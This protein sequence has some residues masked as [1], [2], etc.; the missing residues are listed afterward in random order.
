ML[1]ITIK[2]NQLSRLLITLTAIVFLIA[3][4]SSYALSTAEARHLLSRTGF[5]PSF[6]EIDAVANLNRRQAIDY[7]L[8]SVRQTRQTPLKAQFKIP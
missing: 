6:A 4:S 8:N 1:A 3:S 5:T 2:Q 7:Q